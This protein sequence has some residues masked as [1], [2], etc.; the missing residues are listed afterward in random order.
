MEISYMYR[1]KETI[2]DNDF[3]QPK[4]CVKGNVTFETEHWSD[5]ARRIYKTT[6]EPHELLLTAQRCIEQ[7]NTI[8]GTKYAIYQ[9]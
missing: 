3:D 4:I 9:N 2:L 1:G 8:A 7:L 6:I 5:G